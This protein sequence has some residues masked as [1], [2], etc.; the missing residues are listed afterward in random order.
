MSEP[1]P[2]LSAGAINMLDVMIMSGPQHVDMTD[3]DGRLLELQRCGAVLLA[4]IGGDWH[5]FHTDFGF[6]IWDV[7]VNAKRKEVGHA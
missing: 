5:A 2:N 6:R 7:E 1:M 3:F 4:R